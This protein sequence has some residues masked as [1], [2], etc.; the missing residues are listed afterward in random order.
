MGVEW[1]FFDLRLT[2]GDVVLRGVTDADLPRLVE[3]YPDDCEQDPS[4]ERFAGLDPI[5]D[6]VRLLVQGCWRS[7]GTWSPTSWCLDLAVEVGGAL[8]G[9]QSLEGEE[10]PLLRTTD[11]TSWL[12]T[13]A[14]GRGTGLAMRTAALGFAFGP[15]GAVAAVSSARTDNGVQHLS[16]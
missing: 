6:R 3:L 8:V 16:R 1:P 14:R 5:R 10:F 2:C 4:A 9:V 7:R 15:L 11:S 13:A 12:A